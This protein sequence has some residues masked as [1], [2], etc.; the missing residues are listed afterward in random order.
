M[1]AGSLRG[2]SARLETLL[3]L[4]LSFAAL[5][6]G[7]DRSSV[8]VYDE[9]DVLYGAQRVLQGG[10]PY[11]DFW[12][13]YG[14]AQYWV[15]AALFKLFGSSILVERLWDSLVRAG[16]ATLAHGLSRRLGGRR[17]AVAVWLLTLG[18]LWLVRFYGYPLLPAALFGLGA[19]AMLL[20][21]GGGSR[22]AATPFT[23]GV[24][25]G[26]AGLFRP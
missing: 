4:G 5:L 14:P 20:G 22:R 26:C 2:A 13:I 10:V 3:V 21:A 24:L 16:L 17:I 15:V 23:V 6:F 25:A 7:M 18:W 11:R 1:N 8:G 12:A 9:G 19:V